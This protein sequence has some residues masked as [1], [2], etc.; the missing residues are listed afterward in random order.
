MSEYQIKTYE[1]GIEEE[2]AALGEKI[3][4]DWIDYQ[5]SNAEYLK[6][7][8][9]R[10][11]F[12]PETR[13]YAFKDD[14]LVGYLVSKILPI[15][16]TKIKTIQHDFPFVDKEHEE[17]KELLLNRAMKIYKEKGIQKLQARVSNGWLGTEEL[18]KK[19]G[20]K[21]K[22]IQYMRIEVSLNDLKLKDTEELFE[23]FQ[24]DRDKDQIIKLFTETFNMSEEQAEANFNG[25]VNPPEG[26][27]SQ[28]IIRKDN[29][30]IARG[31]LYIPKDP[32][33]ATFRPLVPNAE[34]YFDSYLNFI[35]KIA[36]EKGAENFQIYIGGP[37][38]EYLDLFKT[39]GFEVKSKVFT[40]EKEI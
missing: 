29:K 36:K 18:A 9:A 21:K 30:I 28:P 11:D 20:Y 35:T 12:D 8:Y 5:Q 27:Y 32:K 2:Q 13:F 1:K 38:L 14:K 24:P 6:T 3:T 4:A 7:V 10:E 19:L 39:Y 17:V 16:D 37:Q 31:L 34:K 15:D 33:N 40:Y 26:F 23:E 25:I 22:D